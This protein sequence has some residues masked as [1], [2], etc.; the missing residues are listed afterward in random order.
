MSKSTTDSRRVLIRTFLEQ[1]ANRTSY[2]GTADAKPANTSELDNLLE[3]IDSELTPLLR[4]DA[5]NP[6]DLTVSIGGAIITNPE[7]ARNRSIPYVGTSIP[8]D[9]S[10]GT[11][12]FPATSGGT[13]T[14][15]PGNNGTLT[16][17]NNN[18]N[19]YPT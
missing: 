10:S 3:S 15:T 1:L 6:I 16:L 19:Y 12:V 17:T 13:V 9:F 8:N 5:S 7:S 11:V 18:N 2:E 14:V 4:M